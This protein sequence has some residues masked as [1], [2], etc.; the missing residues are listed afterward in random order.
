MTDEKLRELHEQLAATGERPVERSASRW[1][2]EA[3][4]IAGDIAGG[5]LEPAVRQKRLQKLAELLDHVETTGDEEADA[6]VASARTIIEEI[7]Q[8]S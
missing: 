6:N 3:E 5:N 7:Q 8:K 2:G 1:L 4:A